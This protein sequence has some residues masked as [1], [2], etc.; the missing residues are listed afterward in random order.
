LGGRDCVIE[1]PDRGLDRPRTASTLSNPDID[2]RA[3]NGN[4]G[5][6]SSDEECVGDNECDDPEETED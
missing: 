1:T 5:K 4:E 2:L 6:F 3:A